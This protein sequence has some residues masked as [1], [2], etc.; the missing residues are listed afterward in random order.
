MNFSLRRS[1]GDTMW[2]RP[3]PGWLDPRHPFGSMRHQ[4][5]HF[6]E[7]ATLAQASQGWTPLSEEEETEDAY[8][9]KAEMPGIPRENI[10]VEMN[11]ND[12]C[13]TGE[14]DTR[15]DKVLTQRNGRFCYRAS[16]S[17]G[18]DSDKTEATL[19]RGV[20]TVRISKS[21]ESKPRQIPITGGYDQRA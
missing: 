1:S 9:I 10:T 2:R 20:L 16:L 4:M 3:S 8:V 17:G 19:D 15:S 7:Q 21:G 5:G 14:L 12:L 18:I 6:L 13:I 11:G